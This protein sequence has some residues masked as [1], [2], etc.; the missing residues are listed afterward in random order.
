MIDGDLHTHCRRLLVGFVLSHDRK[1]YLGISGNGLVRVFVAIPGTLFLGSAR[2]AGILGLGVDITD[3]ICERAAPTG[4]AGTAE[5]ATCTAG[6]A[7]ATGAKA[8]T[9]LKRALDT[10]NDAHA[11]RCGEDARHAGDDCLDGVGVVGGGHDKVEENVDKVDEEDSAVE[12]EV[13]AKHEPPGGERLGFEGFEGAL[14]GE[15]KGGR[16]KDGGGEPVDTDPALVVQRPGNATLTIEEMDGAVETTTNGGDDALDK[17]ETEE[18]ATN[19]GNVVVDGS[20]PNDVDRGRSKEKDGGADGLIRPEPHAI[21]VL[22]DRGR[23]E[24]GA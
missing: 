9:V 15:G 12:V 4:D 8:A 20:D 23:E 11:H 5:T 7:G 1:H 6:A 2:G 13:V 22:L 24:H 14:E 3:G 21:R 10:K 16:V 17:Q 18:E 19:A